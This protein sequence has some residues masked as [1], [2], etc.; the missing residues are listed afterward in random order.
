MRS[1]IMAHPINFF[2]TKHTTL[3]LVDRHIAEHMNHKNDCKK[4]NDLRVMYL[5]H[6][7]PTTHP[8]SW[9]C[10]NHYLAISDTISQLRM[11]SRDA[12]CYMNTTQHALECVEYCD[13]YQ[14]TLRNKNKNEW[15]KS[16]ETNFLAAMARYK[17]FSC[18][19]IT[20][21]GPEFRISHEFCKASW[22]YFE[23]IFHAH[24]HFSI[25]KW[26]NAIACQIPSSLSRCSMTPLQDKKLRNL[27]RKFYNTG[28][29]CV[30]S[31]YFFWIYRFRFCVFK[32]P[33]F[34]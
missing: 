24:T 23:S 11:G 14:K 27:L 30:L 8:F 6:F 15:I 34:Y 32:L 28:M 21:P 9:A 33:L 4:V 29:W 2:P 18:V 1:I 10:M 5:K 3:E 17:L 26:F 12:K 16:G 19:E 20:G 13:I 22:R 7:Q 31:T 25:Q